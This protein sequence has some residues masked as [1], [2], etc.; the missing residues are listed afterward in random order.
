M[1]NFTCRNIRTVPVYYMP[2]NSSFSSLDGFVCILD[3]KRLV[4]FAAERGYVNVL[5]MLHEAGHK[6]DVKMKVSEMLY[7]LS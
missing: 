2:C 7:T 6:M 3:N 1:C 5:R 4:H